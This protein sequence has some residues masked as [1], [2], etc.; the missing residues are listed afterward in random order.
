MKITQSLSRGAL[1][2]L[3]AAPA[4]AADAGVKITS[5]TF[6]GLQARALGPAVMSGRIAAIDA[7]AND[8]LTIYVGAASGGVWKS[9]DAGN[10]F[11]PIFDEHTQSIGAVRVDPSN[12]KTV[13]VGTGESW[14]RNSVSVGTGVYKSTDGG[15]NWTAMGLKD[16]ERI[17]RIQVDSKASDTVY[18][19]ATGH[20]WNANEERGVYKTSDGGK[21]WTRVLFVDSDTGC[22]DLTIDPQEPRI[23]YAAMWQFRRY[24]D[25]FTSGGKGSAIYKSVDGGASWQKLTVGLPTGELGRIG[26][27][28][29]PSRPSVVYAAV[30]SKDSAL[31]R[32]DDAGATWKQMN[33]SFNIGIRAFYF[34]HV[35][36]D[37]QDFNT[38]YK[39]GLTTT[40]STDGGKTFT[41][42]GFGG[43]PH[44]DHHALWINPKNT[45]EMLLGTDGGLY[46]SY[47]KAH[48]WV[49]AKNLPISQFYHVSYDMERP[50]NLY[51]GLQ[52]NNTWTGPS[53]SIGGVE[54]RDWMVI[55][56][57][58]GFWAFADPRDA[59]ILYAESQGGE[60]TRVQR[61]TGEVEA[62][63]PVAAKARGEEELR[64][65]WNTPIHLSPNEPGTLY[66]G[67][68]VLFRSRDRGDS[69]ERISG[70][71]TTD[72]PKRQR[73]K[74]SG[75]INVDNSTAENNATIYSISESPKDR[76]VIW[77]GTDDGYLQVTRDGGKSWTNVT[78]QVPG[79]PAGTWVSR[80]DAGNFDAGTAFVTFDGHRTGDM[81]TYVFATADFG[82]TWSALAKPEIEGY[83]WTIKQDLVN[84]SLL[85]LGTEFG[86]YLSLDSGQQW[87]RFTG[88]LPKVAVHDITIHPREGDLILATHGRGIYIL[89]DLT[90]IRALTTAT[91]A[92]DVVLLPS[93]PTVRKI[94]ATVGS[95]F[96]GDEEF[97]GN[98]PPE[99]AAI[100][101]WLKKRHLFG[102][103]KIEVYDG[104]G[105]LVSSVP[106]TKRVGINRVNW[107]MRLPPPK[108]P[109]STNLAFAFTG[110]RMP[111]GKY[112]IKLIKGKETLEG[113][114][115]LVVDPRSPHSDADRAAQQ[116]MAFAL[117]QGLERMTWI[118]DVA[119]SAGKAATA[120]AERLGKRDALA[121]KLTKLAGR[122]TAFVDSLAA[123]SE[124]GWLSGDERLREKMGNLFGEVN[125][126]DGRPTA[127]QAE[128]AAELLGDLT[129]AEAKFATLRDQDI[130]A[131]NKELAAKKLDPL[132]T[133]AFEDWKAKQDGGGAK[134]AALTLKGMARF[135]KRFPELEAGLNW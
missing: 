35:V 34:A 104:A 65:N 106:G 39:P 100:T 18:V 96:T 107:A 47:D 60:I 124:A 21:T 130:A 31:Y 88:N 92:Q 114:V 14:T 33:A 17:A 49:F 112:R 8:P 86:L 50:Y 43:G 51:G 118:S 57:G 45:H 79:V 3:L 95:G 109:P 52:D 25:F 135:A 108:M 103:L 110:P 132:P 91:M 69:W 61:S 127:S 101:Y 66:I 48:H 87:A 4:L 23:L 99:A 11:K 37:P 120:H 102:D 28:V 89:D 54:N 115:Q 7:V 9:V 24:P 32:S 58:D 125:R 113:E 2:A 72:D 77:V 94:E 5:D 70:D 12:A 15:D 116:K 30:E 42:T 129:V 55:G 1:L 122:L 20:L 27:A 6:G 67:A 59:D 111:E 82:Q 117:Y 63:Q 74:L 53:E 64:F 68:Q 16:S 133:P 71:L 29:A 97:V 73:Q 22:A 98:N 44:G 105:K 38:V 131:A 62:I 41:G 123:T 40:I 121:T 78:A 85:F 81:K 56:G 84:P 76:N 128:N 10:T 83:A 80:V 36:V 119:S 93:R 19:C 46:L 75:G 126:F 90:P 26:I 134:G 13:W